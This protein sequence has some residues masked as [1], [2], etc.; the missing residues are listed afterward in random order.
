[1][2]A[3]LLEKRHFRVHLRP[4]DIKDTLPAGLQVE[5]LEPAL[6]MLAS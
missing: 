3:F 2:R 4:D 5:E 1:M 6:A